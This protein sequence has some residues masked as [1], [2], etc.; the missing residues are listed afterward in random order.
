M[1]ETLDNLSCDKN[2]ATNILPDIHNLDQNRREIDRLNQQVSNLKILIGGKGKGKKTKIHHFFL[3]CFEISAYF[4]YNFYTLYHCNI[5]FF[6]HRYI[7]DCT[8]SLR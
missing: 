5:C 2:T 6:D 8:A 4:C 1:E 7:K 3:I